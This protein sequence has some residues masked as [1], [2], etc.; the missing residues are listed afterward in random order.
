MLTFF[1]TRL[2]SDFFVTPRK[3]QP[4]L[5]SPVPAGQAALPAGGSETFPQRS[6]HWQGALP[7][8][9]LGRRNYTVLLY[10][11]LPEDS[12]SYASCCF[13]SDSKLA[14]PFSPVMPGDR[15]LQT[16]APD[17][18]GEVGRCERSDP[19]HC[20]AQDGALSLAQEDR[21]RRVCK[22]CLC[23]LR[24]EES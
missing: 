9:G 3:A 22:C 20:P 5:S 8:C 10:W 7:E 17:L 18:E 19:H 14:F 16:C 2:S 21:S 15:S 12:L 6:S 23:T 4:G 24:R 11:M 1:K 13:C